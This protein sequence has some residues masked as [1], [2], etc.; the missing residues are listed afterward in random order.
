MKICPEEN[1][2]ARRWFGEMKLD[3]IPPGKWVLVFVTI[4]SME[5]L[6]QV[7]QMIFVAVHVNYGSN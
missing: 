2:S 4:R 1:Y 5:S 3:K 7:V 6:L